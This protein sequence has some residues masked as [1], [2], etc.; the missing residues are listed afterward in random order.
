MVGTRL[1][2]RPVHTRSYTCRMLRLQDSSSW[3]SRPLV[4][5]RDIHG[6]LLTRYDCKEDCA[7]SQSQAR[8]GARGGRSSQDGVSQQQEA[9]PLFLPQLNR[10]NEAFLVRGVD[11]FF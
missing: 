1:V 4:L 10:F 7:P 8:V 3:S 2:V 9:A 11:A 5:L 6:N